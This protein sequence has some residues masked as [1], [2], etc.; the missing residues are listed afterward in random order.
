MKAYF[1]KSCIRQWFCLLHEKLS[2]TLKENEVKVRA[3]YVNGAIDIMQGELNGELIQW[4][5]KLRG[6]NCSTCT[7]NDCKKYEFCQGCYRQILQHIPEI[8]K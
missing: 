4:I 2:E 1:Y 5:P 8:R 6:G 3:W 7:M